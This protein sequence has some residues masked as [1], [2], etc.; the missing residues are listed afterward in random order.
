VAFVAL[1]DACVLYPAPLRDL[2]LRLAATDA[3]RVRW[4]EQINAEWFGAVTSRRPALA[5]R[6]RRTLSNMEAAF[7]DALVTGHAALIDRLDL[8]DPNDRHVLAAA[9]VGRADVIVTRNLRDFPAATLAPY[10]IEAQHPD[11]FIRHAL[12]LH[13]AVMLDA[14]RRHR[15]SH[16]K[17]PFDPAAYLDLLARQELPETVAFLRLFVGVI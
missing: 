13:Q 14:V 2:L 1:L 11:T 8:P 9:I 17:P 4:S 5:D 16:R 15:A 10:G 7:P 12:D 6:L 3:F